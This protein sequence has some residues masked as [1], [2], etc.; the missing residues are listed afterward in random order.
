MYYILY[1]HNMV[2]LLYT[3]NV[4][5]GSGYYYV[6]DYTYLGKPSISHIPIMWF[7]V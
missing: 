7:R 4:V 6:S 3:P 5:E 1:T 2:Y